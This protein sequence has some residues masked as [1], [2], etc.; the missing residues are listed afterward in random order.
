M[1]FNLAL[2]DPLSQTHYEKNSISPGLTMGLG[3]L[4]PVTPLD[5]QGSLGIGADLKLEYLNQNC[6]SVGELEYIKGSLG[7]Q[8]ML[9][10]HR[11]YFLFRPAL[12]LAK[13]LLRNGSSRANGVALGG[14]LGLGIGIRM[15]KGTYFQI[16][17]DY[18]FSLQP[19]N[20]WR[21]GDSFK[22]HE[23]PKS[24][25]FSLGFVVRI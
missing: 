18:N 19:I 24:I 25:I 13:T 20:M 4:T 21:T 3:F 15:G 2:G 10:N 9:Q 12:S 11:A 5:N 14:S 7:L 16:Y 1:E 6:C 22:K 23:Y 17:G 8:C